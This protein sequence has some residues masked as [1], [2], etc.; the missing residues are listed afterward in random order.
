VFNNLK[1]VNRPFEEAD[2]Q[3][4]DQMSNYWV[5]FIKTGNP[6]G[7]KSIKWPVYTSEKD[8]VLILDKQ[9]SA[10]SIPFKEGLRILSTVY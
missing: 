8:Q 3:L 5:N 2:I 7:A 6:N 1:T 4:A 9:I 10:Q